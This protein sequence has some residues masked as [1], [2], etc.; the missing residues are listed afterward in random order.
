M[1]GVINPAGQHPFRMPHVYA[2]II[3]GGVSRDCGINHRLL[4]LLIP[5]GS[6]VWPIS[7]APTAQNP[8]AQPSRAGLWS[9]ATGG[10]KGRDFITLHCAPI[11]LK[12]T[13][14]LGIQHEEP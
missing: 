11:P 13:H 9:L 8:I 10:L 7:A 3:S 4:F 6:G 5:S 1:L 2:M 14:P 12:F